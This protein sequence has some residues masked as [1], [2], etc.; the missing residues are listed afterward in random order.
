MKRTAI[1]RWI[2]VYAG[3]LAVLGLIA[4]LL[5][6]IAPQLFL[7]DVI[8]DPPQQQL[9][10]LYAGRSITM[11]LVMAFALYK[12]NPDYLFLAFLMRLLTELFDTI[13]MVRANVFNVPPFLLLLSMIIVFIIPEALALRKL[14]SLSPTT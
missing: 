9:L 5:G 11:G 10:G 12:R 1:P 2:T 6:F 8:I 3:F 4:G 7:P 14:A 13:V